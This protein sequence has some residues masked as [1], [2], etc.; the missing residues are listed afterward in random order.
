[1]KTNDF[2]T[3]LPASS[4][5]L[6][7]LTIP[8]PF[9]PPVGFVIFWAISLPLLAVRPERYRIPALI[10]SIAVTISVIALLI[11]ALAK[12]GGGGPLL[13]Q[14]QKTTG[15]APLKGAK[16][17]WAMARGVTTTIGGWAGG[18]SSTRL[19]LSLSSILTVDRLTPASLDY[20]SCTSRTSRD[21]LGS[22]ETRVRPSCSLVALP[23]RSSLTPS[24]RFA[25][26]R[27]PDLH[28]S[29]LS[30]HGKLHRSHRDLVCW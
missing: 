21:M 27:W 30:D 2:S 18:V 15:I 20:R 25:F 22:L 4:T 8:S 28:H 11:W 5:L 7:P 9:L 19:V 14:T 24:S 12:E 10:S 29:G 6:D 17:G 1:M 13:Y 26:S 23:L 3:F 16:L